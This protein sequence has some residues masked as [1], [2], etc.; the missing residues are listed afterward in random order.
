[1]NL[2]MISD[3]NTIRFFFVSH[4]CGN[5]PELHKNRHRFFFTLLFFQKYKQAKKRRPGDANVSGGG[6]C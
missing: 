6:S 4:V 2:I 5:I 1:M 3:T